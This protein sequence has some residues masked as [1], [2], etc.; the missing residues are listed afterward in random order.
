MSA[1]V[2]KLDAD[3]HRSVQA[4]LPWY[5][6]QRLGAEDLAR[7]ET[8]LAA[9]PHCQAELAWER[10]LQAARLEHDDFRAHGDAEAGLV[11]LRS[12]IEASRSEQPRARLRRLRDGVRA[13]LRDWRLAWQGSAAPLRWV[14]GGVVGAQSAAILALLVAVAL[15]QT[16]SYRALGQAARPAAGNVVVMFRPEAREQELRHALAAG[17]ARLVNGPTAAGAYVL[18]VPPEQRQAA[19]AQLRAQSAVMLAEPLDGGAAP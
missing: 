18:S 15:P 2:V 8:H 9:C 3:T 14:V 7:V 4:L 11:L 13:A 10:R 6:T 12:R 19:L 5:V 1:R 17:G 16:H